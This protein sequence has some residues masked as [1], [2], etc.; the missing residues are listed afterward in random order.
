LLDRGQDPLPLI[1]DGLAAVPGDH[2]L[3]FLAARAYLANGAFETALRIARELRAVD[4][5]AL[6]D[7]LL[8][9]DRRIF[10][11]FAD[12]LAGTAAFR[13]GDFTAASHHFDAAAAVAP[14]NPAYR[15]KARAADMQQPRRKV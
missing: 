11:E 3:R 8:A 6:S 5:Q 7:G 13:L 14:D 9:F 12:D 10:S 15:L 2:A 4:A 1:S